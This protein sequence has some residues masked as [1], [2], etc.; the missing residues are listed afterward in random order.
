[1]KA[2]NSLYISSVALI[3][4]LLPH[5]S[6]LSSGPII[7]TWYASQPENMT[8]NREF[9]KKTFQIEMKYPSAADTSE[10]AREAIIR[11]CERDNSGQA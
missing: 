5:L 1:L 6:S 7:L 9:L 11:K 8:K 10:E 4:L 2:S 3:A